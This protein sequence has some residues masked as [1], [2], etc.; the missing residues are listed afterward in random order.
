MTERA[1]QVAYRPQQ[2][3]NWWLRSGHYFLY[4]VRELSS[5]FAAVWVLLFLT[6]LPLMAGGPSQYRAWL[7]V[8]RSPEWITFSVIAL[9]FVLYHSWTAFTSTSAIVH[10]RMGKD[11]LGGP[12]VNLGMF[13]TWAGASLV[14]GIIFAA[15]VTGG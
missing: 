5:V 11:T 10:F 8:I 13:M 1:A 12:I 9:L 3:G 7:E 4:M 14:I 2:P 15:A 6:Q